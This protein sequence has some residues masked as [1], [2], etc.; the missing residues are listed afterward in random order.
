MKG[1]YG[2]I[3]ELSPYFF[4]GLYAMEEVLLGIMN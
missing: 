1:K 4:Y 2:P 3:K